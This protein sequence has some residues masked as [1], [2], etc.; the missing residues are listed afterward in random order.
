MASVPDLVAKA[1]KLGQPGL[2][3]TDHGVMGSAFE[4]YKNCK[5][6][7][8]KPFPGIEAYMV[9]SVA[10]VR[11]AKTD[12]RYHLTLLPLNLDGYKSL[13]GLTS[14]SATEARFYRKPLIDY[15]DL[16]RL[17]ANG[18]TKNIACLSGCF[19]GLLNQT[20]VTKGTRAARQVATM[21]SSWFPNFFIEIQNHNIDRQEDGG[22]D[23]H[24]LALA[25]YSLADKLGLPVICTQDAHYLEMKHKGAHAAMKSLAYGSLLGDDEF[26]G[27]SY[28]LCGEKFVSKHFLDDLELSTIWHAAQPSYDLLI[29]K[30]KLS[31]PPL[32][33][34]QFLMPT[35]AK[36]PDRDLRR[37][38]RQSLVA[39]GIDPN[40][41]QEDGGA[42]G[43]YAV[44]AAE[45]LDTIVTTGFSGYFLMVKDIC[46]WA[47]DKGIRIQPRGSANGS[48]VCHL[49]GIS[50]IDP[51][52][53]DLSMGGFLTKDRS[54]PP[55]IDLDCQQLRRHEVIEYVQ[56]RY[57]SMQQGTPSR[58]G[59]DEET[60]KGSLFLHYLQSEQ[61]LL[62]P[63][64]FKKKWGDVT[65]PAKTIRQTEPELYSMLHQL[66]AIKPWK[67][68]G[69]HAAGYVLD[70]QVYPLA[71][72]VPMMRIASSDSIVTAMPMDPLEEAGY[73][74]LDLLGLRELES[75]DRCIQMPTIGMSWDDVEKIPL[76]DSAVFKEISRTQPNN[77]TFQLKGYSVAKGV[78][79]MAPKNIDE[80]I[81]AVAL[82]RPGVPPEAVDLYMRN[83][84][85]PHTV[86]Y[87]HHIV[88]PILKPTFGVIVFTEQVLEIAR[89][90]GMTP[91]DVQS[92]LKAMKVKHGKAGYNADSERRFN[93]AK[94][95]FTDACAA[96]GMGTVADELWDRIYTF[97]KYAFKKAHATPYGILAY[98]TAWFRHHFP[99]EFYVSLLD[100][101]NESKPQDLD[102]YV[103]AARQRGVR[104]L[105]P[106]VN[107][108]GGSWTLEDGAIR[109]GL[110]SIPG[111]GQ[112]A[113]VEIAMNSP[114]KKVEEIEERCAT[115]LVSGFKSWNGKEM[116]F[117]GVML[118]LQEA[119]ALQELGIPKGAKRQPRILKLKP[120]DP[121]VTVRLKVK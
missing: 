11:A 104:I 50:N 9:D 87:L 69:R 112:S 55:D 116:K 49:L 17:A 79:R 5:K 58:W 3:I 90:I 6:A 114:Y 53:W 96:V 109:K 91:E 94:D 66:N 26:P 101:V 24:D 27:D 41:G 117:N 120:L 89:A 84:A 103:R 110:A 54:K 78:R 97:N 35:V 83:R 60:G 13:V 63:V 21:F 70:S 95:K 65:E 8:I 77:G 25:L 42:L 43:V 14:Y 45:E 108:S 51:I 37:A 16:S 29:A 18:E 52:K 32:D 71:E 28:H 100:V 75:L 39:R 38:V 48:L 76:T 57:P 31:I 10:R 67:S 36:D 64:A 46:D 93:E 74:K 86:T 1:V 7:D 62:G 115:R 111:V 22:W 19:F 82:F 107:H 102:M 73:V 33:N 80:V 85:K 98:W 68:Y 105:P 56:H 59:F 121:P 44:R 12:E 118:K 2:A 40:W 81:H 23:D 15:E 72:Y 106:M 119:G 4:L 88:E 30:N 61:R 99:A 47:R 34:Y 92:L 113:A 20:L